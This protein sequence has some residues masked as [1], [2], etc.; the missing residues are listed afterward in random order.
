[1]FE[2]MSNYLGSGDFKLPTFLHHCKLTMTDVQ[3]RYTIHMPIHFQFSY[4]YIYVIHLGG[5]G[6]GK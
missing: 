2:K 1:M 6:G 5:S 3:Y 4:I